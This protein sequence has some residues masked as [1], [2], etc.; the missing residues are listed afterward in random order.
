MVSDSDIKAEKFLSIASQYK[1][2]SLVTETPHP[3]TADLSSLAENNLS[4]AISI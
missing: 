1:L 2:G 4:E 3:A